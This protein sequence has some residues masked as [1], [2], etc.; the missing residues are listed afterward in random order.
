M[1]RYPQGDVTEK[2][3]IIPVHQFYMHDVD[4]FVVRFTENPFFTT[5]VVQAGYADI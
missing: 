3:Y 1:K 5:C 4:I 2:E